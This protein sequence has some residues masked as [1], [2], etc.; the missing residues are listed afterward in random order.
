M[1]NVLLEQ[2][3]TY[4]RQAAEAGPANLTSHQTTE[5]VIDV[6]LALY[7]AAKR[8]AERWKDRVRSGQLAMNVDDARGLDENYRALGGAFDRIA[9]HLDAGRSGLDARCVERFERAH[10]EL[11]SLLSIP[12]EAAVESA[13][14][15]ERGEVRPFGEVMDELCRGHH[16]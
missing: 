5:D 10:A 8:A 16:G 15:S 2:V 3:H 1:T 6:G 13:G 14:Q 9:H 12:F 11:R 7:E 4:R